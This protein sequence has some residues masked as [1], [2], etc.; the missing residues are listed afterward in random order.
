MVNSELILR[1]KRGSIDSQY[2]SDRIVSGE[3]SERTKGSKTSGVNVSII[4]RYLPPIECIIGV[5]GGGI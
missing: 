2:R 4:A 1:W 5:V 3:G